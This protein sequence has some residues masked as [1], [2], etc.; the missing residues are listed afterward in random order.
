MLL[1]NETVNLYCGS[2]NHVP[3]RLPSELTWI[4][5]YTYGFEPDCFAL[6]RH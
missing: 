4:K 1:W 2:D 6:S 5:L 3:A